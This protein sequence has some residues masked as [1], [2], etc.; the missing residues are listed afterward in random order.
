MGE[1]KNNRAGEL[2][3]TPSLTH[4]RASYQ[5]FNLSLRFP[6]QKIEISVKLYLYYL[7]IHSFIQYF[8]NTYYMP[9][10]YQVLEQDKV[11]AFAGLKFQTIKKS[12]HLTGFMWN[13]I[14]RSSG[15]QSSFFQPTITV[16]I[17]YMLT[18]SLLCTS[19]LIFT[20]IV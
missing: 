1:G 2:Y 17:Y 13:E 10:I 15:Y 20:T 18:V 7:I 3:S 14:T 12:P 8:W 5:A 6:T 19:H 16:N 11:S 4:W 9:G